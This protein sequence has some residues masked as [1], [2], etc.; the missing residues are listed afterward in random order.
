MQLVFAFLVDPHCIS[1]IQRTCRT[2]RRWNYHTLQKWKLD[3]VYKNVEEVLGRE[4]TKQLRDGSLFDIYLELNNFGAKEAKAI[5]EAL[6]VNTSLTSINLSTNNIGAEGA[7]T[8]GEALKVN[9]SLTR[10]GL[11][12]N[13]IGTGGAEAIGEALKVNTSLTYIGLNGINIGAE[14]EKSE[15]H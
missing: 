14:G 6:K 10:I 8:I 5:A 7:K 3:L 9:T 1:N 4:K 15:R 13:N 2:T 11:N 12:T